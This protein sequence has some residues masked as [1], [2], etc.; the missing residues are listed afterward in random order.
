[1]C[2]ERSNN[3]GT[4]LSS[5]CR[6]TTGNEN[7]SWGMKEHFWVVAVTC[8]LFLPFH[9]SV[10]WCRQLVYRELL[11]FRPFSCR[12]NSFFQFIPAPRQR[13]R[14]PRHWTGNFGFFKCSG[15]FWYNTASG[16]ISE[17][18]VWSHAIEGSEWTGDG[19]KENWSLG[20]CVGFRR[21]QVPPTF[22]FEVSVSQYRWREDCGT[23]PAGWKQTP[24][25]RL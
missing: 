17:L 4:P 10:S 11:F 14:Q 2:S 12:K 3:S 23:V 7:G 21:K 9:V 16:K 22:L 25:R 15:R 13:T 19:S 18:K 8:P 20:L 24:T 6:L 1:M 5:M